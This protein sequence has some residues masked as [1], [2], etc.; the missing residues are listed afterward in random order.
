MTLIDTVVGSALMLV[1]FLGI[2]AAF[3][4]SVD[5]VTNNK[6]RGGAIA[7]AAERMEYIRSLT[8][9]SVGTSGGIP[10]GGIAQSETVV[11][12]G[13]TYTRRTVVEY[14][15][16][17]K[18][19]SG[20]AD[21]N[22]ITSDYKVAKVDVAWTSRTGTR[23][24]TLV[25]RF[26]PP[27]GMEIACAPP[28]GTLTVN[29]ANAASQPLSSVSV[30]IVNASTT[31]PININTFTNA[32]GTVSFIGAPASAGYAIVVTKTGY[33]TARTYSVTSGNSDPNPGNLTVSNN[34]TTVG[35]F[36]IDIL[37]TLAVTTYSLSTNT[38]SD[39]FSNDSKIG[40]STSN[41]EVSGNRARFAGSQPWTAPADLYSLTI[42]PTAL[43]R[44]GTFSWNDTQPAETTI[45]YHVYYPT[46]PTF[47]LL[48]DSV[49]AGNSTGF[50]A[51]TS[52]DLSG[53]PASIYPSLVLHAHLVA[54]NPSAPS[55]SIEDWEL[56]YES[57]QGIAIPFT[58]R[59]IKTIGNGPSGV[60]YK[61]DQVHT[62]NSSG[63]LTLPAMEWDTYTM[64]VATPTGYDIAS[65]CPTQPMVLAPN[66]SLAAQIFFSAHTDNSLLV[67]V[68]NPTGGLLSGASV[69]LT[70]GGSYDK[71]TT[72]DACGQAFFSALTNGNY[73]IT[74]SSTGY[75]TYSS[76]LVDVTDTSRF[77]ITLN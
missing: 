32:S 2:G 11:Q 23:H 60:I 21:G 44:W 72:T 16:D 10:A 43:S 69:H 65:S 38:W 14:A 42:T 68:K 58:L 54:L 40:A 31:P 1:I 48:P 17:P 47:S 52:V 41:I 4:L 66:S 20:A 53:V 35:T 13:I 77:S 5:V 8:Y 34:Q 62:T 73:S 71:T 76:D 46:G 74:A 64:T 22:G 63:T 12:N 36:Q 26:E 24:I 30:S 15:D 51:G 75:Q 57:G 19:G 49:L 29:V 33:S 61:Y 45:T 7:L 37:S 56:T 39:T 25:S 27:A 9:A 67:D 59:G 70:K 3:Q 50:S 18:D 6:A 55:P 28:C